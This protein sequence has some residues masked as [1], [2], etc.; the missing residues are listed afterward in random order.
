[1]GADGRG[2][3]HVGVHGVPNPGHNHDV[4]RPFHADRDVSWPQFF[5]FHAISRLGEI[6]S[7]V[8]Q[9]TVLND[10]GMSGIAPASVGHRP[11]NR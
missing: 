4:K 2:T 9:C 10:A 6:S 3:P 11:Y 8:S 7:E 1:M 5:V